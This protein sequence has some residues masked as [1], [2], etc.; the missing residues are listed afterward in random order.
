MSRWV[1]ALLLFVVSTVVLMGATAQAQTPTISGITPTSGK[2][3]TQITITGQG[4]FPAVPELS[5]WLRV[6]GQ[7]ATTT[8]WTDTQI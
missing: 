5:Y 2:I 8:S 3:G 4:L 7:T 1:R 6:G